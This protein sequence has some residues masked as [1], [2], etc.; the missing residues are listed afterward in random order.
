V[1]V[2]DE[3]RRDPEMAEL[4]GDVPTVELQALTTELDG[5][6]RPFDLWRVRPATDRPTCTGRA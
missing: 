5:F 4:A 1:V 3:V 6:D 2:S